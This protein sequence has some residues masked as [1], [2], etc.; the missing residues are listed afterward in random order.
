MQGAASRPTFTPV[1]QTVQART[2]MLLTSWNVMQLVELEKGAAE[3]KPPS[4]PKSL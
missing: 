2:I 3:W 4:L 1:I